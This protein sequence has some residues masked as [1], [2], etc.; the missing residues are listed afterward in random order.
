MAFARPLLITPSREHAWEGR[1]ARVI[2]VDRS[3]SNQPLIEGARTL[4][5]R[6]AEGAFVSRV[7]E[8]ADVAGAVR[9]VAGLFARLPPARRELVVVSDLQEAAVEPAAFEALP[10]G[11]GIRFV[12]SGTP[13]NARQPPPTG[14]PELLAP[15]AAAG[16]V[17]RALASVARANG[18]RTTAR[19]AR[20]VVGLRG[21]PR[22]EELHRRGRS[23]SAPWMADVAR[24]IVEAGTRTSGGLKTE[25]A[26]IDGRLLVVA[27]VDPRSFDFPVLLDAIVRGLRSQHALRES[28]LPGVDPRQLAALERPATGVPPGSVRW[29]AEDDAR[30]FW[31]I[32][33]ILLGA[34]GWLRSRR[35][36]QES[37]GRSGVRAA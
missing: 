20:V 26:S 4:A 17:T 3:E 37:T 10:R 31:V 32:A 19:D 22:V 35:P 13:S 6:E 14:L 12:R 30:W 21:V 1:V 33:A 11:V 18:L 34:E 24:A 16:A 5:R 2:L 9:Q 23:V 36:T 7:V 28:L 27:D 15:D 29:S 8:T 25:L